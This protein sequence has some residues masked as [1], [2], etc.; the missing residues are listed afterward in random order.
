V[1]PVP[2]AAAATAADPARV[3]VLAAVIAWVGAVPMFM[4]TKF[5]ATVAHEGGHALVGRLFA[6]KV[7]SIR[8]ERSGDA[9]TTFGGKLPWLVDVPVTMMGHLG[10]SAFGL[11]AAWLA[12]RGYSA[13]VFWA[14]LGFLVVMLFVVRG[15]VGWLVVPSLVVLVFLVALYTEPPTQ[16]LLAHVWAWFLLIAAV[17][18]SL[19]VMRGGVYAKKGSDHDELRRLT[20]LPPAVWG[21][22]LLAGSVAALAYGGRMLLRLE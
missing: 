13:A 21:V 10:P 2:L 14:S 18:Q 9:A 15:P 4:V 11:G 6:Q 7:V 12:V 17:E 19:L 8:L 3:A 16:A 20:L 5:A 22:L 1:A